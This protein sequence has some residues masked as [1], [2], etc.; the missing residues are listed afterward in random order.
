[1]GEVQA[2]ATNQESKA[3]RKQVIVN[4]RMCKNNGKITANKRFFEIAMTSTQALKRFDATLPMSSYEL[5]QQAASLSGMTVRSFVA[6][7]AF[8]HALKLLKA[9]AEVKTP[10]IALNDE[11]SQTL[12]YL[13]ENEDQIFGPTLSKYRQIASKVRIVKGK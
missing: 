2:S 9:T 10:K 3:S 7:A 8:E 5:V 12:A 1:M 4:S 11:E 13:M 6:M